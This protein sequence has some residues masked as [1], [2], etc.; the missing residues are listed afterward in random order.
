MF[1]VG[2]ESLGKPG[3]SVFT[4][5]LYVCCRTDSS[6][7]MEYKG[8]IRSPPMKLKTLGFIGRTA[9]DSFSEKDL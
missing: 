9:T 8:A 5:S 1:R 3:L 2:L 7:L 6:N 4:L